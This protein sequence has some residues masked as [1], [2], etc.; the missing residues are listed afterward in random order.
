[1]VILEILDLLIL[2]TSPVVSGHSADEALTV[3]PTHNTNTE[4]AFISSDFLFATLKV[5]LL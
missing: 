4:M 2:I 3:L 1:M 5:L